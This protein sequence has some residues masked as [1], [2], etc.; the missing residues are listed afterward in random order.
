MKTKQ[1][2]FEEVFDLFAIRIVIES[3]YQDPQKEK[4][5]CWKLYALLTDVYRPNMGRTR[6]WISTSKNNG[7]ES[8]HVTLMSYTGNWIEVQIR[9]T[10]MDE[11][12]EKGYAAQWKYKQLASTEEHPQIRESGLDKWLRHINEFLA[13]NTNKNDAISL[14]D[15]IKLDLYNDEIII[16]TPKGE[17]RTMPVGSTVLDF[18]YSIHSDL[19]DRA[20]GAKVNHNTVPL[21]H[22]LKSGSQVEVI[23]S[24]KQKPAE[25]WLDFVI[26]SRAKSAIRRKIEDE[27]AK[28]AETGKNILENYLKKLNQQAN[29]KNIAL[30][31]SE[32]LTHNLSDLYYRIATEKLKFEDI[33]AVFAK[34]T[35][36]NW[37]LKLF[38][39]N[40][41]KLKASTI[42]GELERQIKERPESVI[43]DKEMKD[44]QY[45]LANCC[46]PISGEDVIGIILPT[47]IIEIHRI[48]CPNA[49]EL[50]SRFGDKIIKTKWKENEL[51]S[52]LVGIKIFGKDRQG[53]MFDVTNVISQGLDVNMKSINIETIEGSFEGQ[54][55][56]YITDLLH[57]NTLISE[58]RRVKGISKV[59]RLS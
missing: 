23:T 37:L 50:M 57:L 53:L 27:K 45:E 40:A 29:E 34:K 49:I 8:L 35:S 9:T 25:E 58:L 30:I 5:D 54:I 10:R 48:N 33:N 47:G 52:F 26:T 38:S 24:K 4:N 46:N 16:F 2:L 31:I 43:L 36:P 41:D 56:L 44:I 11:I 21:N 19:G 7:Y 39:I 32:T 59:F 42:K 20:I 17:F 18:A 14:L 3:D 1:I 55:M 6:D 12:A 51:V 13:D 15:D 22:L 28:F